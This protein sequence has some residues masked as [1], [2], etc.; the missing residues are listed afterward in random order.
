MA[1][2]RSK[3]IKLNARGDL[4]VGNPLANGSVLAIGAANTVLKSDGTD[5]SWSTIGASSLSLTEGN[6]FVGGPGDIAIE[7]GAVSEGQVMVSG[8]GPNFNFAVGNLSA[9]FLTFTPNPPNNIA[10]TTVQN[11]IVEVAAERA[12]LHIDSVDPLPTNDSVDTATLGEFF[13]IGDRWINTITDNVFTLVDSS[14]STAVWVRDAGVAS[15]FVYKG[16]L[17]AGNAGDTLPVG[18]Q[19]GDWYRISATDGT[20]NFNAAWDAS[21]EP[22]GATFE[23][24]DAVVFGDDGNWHKIDNTDPSVQAGNGITVSAGSNYTVSVDADEVTITATG[25]TGTEL[26]VFGGDANQ[27]LLGVNATSD[28]VW[29][30]LSD[31]RDSTGA[32]IVDGVEVASAVNNIAISNSAT[33]I[34]PSITATGTDADIDLIIDPKGTGNLQLDGIQWPNNGIPPHLFLLPIQQ[35]N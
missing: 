33:G 20:Q 26:S 19:A 14:A 9:A 22:N 13:K 17:D 16:D 29:G 27:V 34:A 10:A 11:A 23:I 12:Y 6:M 1:Q 5:P 18:P 35:M 32:L 31:L 15:A 3:Q 21:G 4:I 28:A 25:G 30:F 7:A 8:P 2:I 24:G